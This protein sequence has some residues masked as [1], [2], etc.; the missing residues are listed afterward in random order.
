[1]GSKNMDGGIWSQ[2]LEQAART[3]EFPSSHFL[4]LGELVEPSQ[5]LALPWESLEL[6]LLETAD[7]VD[8]DMGCDQ[9]A[10]CLYVS[11]SRW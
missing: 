7:Y 5:S 2:I 10:Q 8:A 6:H 3:A 4:L 1:M 9:C 11:M